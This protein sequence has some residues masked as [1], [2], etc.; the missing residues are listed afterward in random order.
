M[1]LSCQESRLP[2]ISISACKEQLKFLDVG[3]S[4]LRVV[5]PSSQFISG[6]AIRY[7]LFLSTSD[8]LLLERGLPRGAVHGLLFFVF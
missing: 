3:A 6:L 4:P 2:T 7:F 5:N 8:S 1:R